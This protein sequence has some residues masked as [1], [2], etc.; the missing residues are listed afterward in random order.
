MESSKVQK[1]I[2]NQIN[3]LYNKCPL[4][5]SMQVTILAYPILTPQQMGVTGRNPTIT[6]TVS[7]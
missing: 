3:I 4:K 7:F 1:S 2:H 6:L 5:T